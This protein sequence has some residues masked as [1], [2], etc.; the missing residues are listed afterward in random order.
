[1][2]THKTYV[3]KKLSATGLEEKSILSAQFI[4]VVDRLKADGHF[5][6]DEEFCEHYGY[7]K[8][9]L[10]HLRKGRQDVSIELLYNVVI[11][12]KVNPYFV[13]GLS[14]KVYADTSISRTLRK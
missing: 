5:A 11:Y 9:M 14:N 1:M 10:N 2:D 8:K 13:F 4:K 3:F 7:S 12:W 6:I